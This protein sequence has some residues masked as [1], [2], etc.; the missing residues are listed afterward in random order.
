MF[1]ARIE[2]YDFNENYGALDQYEKE[3]Q[4]NTECLICLEKT[5]STLSKTQKFVSI[6]AK[7]KIFFKECKCDCWVHDGCVEVWISRKGSRIICRK[8]F[9]VLRHDTSQ[10]EELYSSQNWYIHFVAI[11]VNILFPVF[12]LVTYSNY[13]RHIITRILWICKFFFKLFFILYFIGYIFACIH[14]ILYTCRYRY[15]SRA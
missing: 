15:I 3:E 9:T 1:F 13:T 10:Q 14:C 6:I 8:Y 7:R 12:T 11:H 4:E 5:D 2:H